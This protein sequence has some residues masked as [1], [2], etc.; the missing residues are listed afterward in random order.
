MCK[1]PSPLI[2]LCLSAVAVVFVYLCTAI[3]AADDPGKDRDEEKQ[4]E[5]QAK[6]VQR[7]A[8]QYTLSPAGENKKPFKFHEVP[9]MKWGNP[10]GGAKDGAIHIWSDGN[11]PQAILKL[12]SHDGERFTHEWQSLAEGAIVAERDGSVVWNPDKAGITFLELP[13]APK[14]GENATSRLRQMKSLADKFSGTVTRLAKDSTPTKLRLLTQ[15]MFRF[16]TGDSPE[17]P[18]G[19]LFGFAEGTD[20]AALLLLEARRTKDG[21]RWHYAFTK[22]STFAITGELG[23]KEIYSAP[24]Y[25]FSHD[26]KDIFFRLQQQRLPAK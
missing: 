23:G 20:P 8:A 7:S 2:M 19:A 17:R 12:F 18:D 9:V 22:L 26:P 10:I 5:E 3:F 6:R 13:D 16:E 15:P 4:R 1:K 25:D 24:K 14:P 11:R 21:D